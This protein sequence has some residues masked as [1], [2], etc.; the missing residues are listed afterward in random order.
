MLSDILTSSK[1]IDL[2][3]LMRKKFFETLFPRIADCWSIRIYTLSTCRRIAFDGEFNR[4]FEIV[5]KEF[6]L[7]RVRLTR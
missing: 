4:T 3:K 6:V 7:E 1:N 5:M 2:L